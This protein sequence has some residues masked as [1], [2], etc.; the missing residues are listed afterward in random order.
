MAQKKY[1]VYFPLKHDGKDYKKDD[2]VQMEEEAAAYLVERGVIALGKSEP[3]EPNA[4]LPEPVIGE[5]KKQE[6][7]AVQLTADP[8][9]P[10]EGA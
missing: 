9:T 10:I 3:V 7:A 4:G 5:P 8:G 1:T 6:G 2:T